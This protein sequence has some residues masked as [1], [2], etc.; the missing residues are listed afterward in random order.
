MANADVLWAFMLEYSKDWGIRAHTH[1][2][3]Q[4]YYITSGEGWMSIE[5]TH[6]H[7][8]PKLCVLI[9]PD[10]EHELFKMQNG[11][12]RMIDIKFYVHDAGLSEELE[13]LPQTQEMNQNFQELLSDIRSEWKL[14]LPFRKN[15]VD[16][17][18]EQALYLLVRAH[19]KTERSNVI[20]SHIL[21]HT[22]NLTGLPQTMAQYIRSRCFDHL[23]LDAMAK[24]LTY[25]RNYLCKVF[26]QA[27]GMTII[28]YA[29]YVRVERALELIC[30]SDEKISTISEMSGFHD[31]H[32]FAKVFKEITKHTPGELR[33]RQEYDMYTDV[34]E[35]GKFIYRYYEP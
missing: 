18:M 14:M 7:L 33:N 24:E 16:I 23:S 28:Q 1:D 12:L 25:N 6:I 30:Y 27:T 22:K 15:M 19:A 26:K 17:L 29:N 13:K 5:N 20:F 21:D 4:L 11:P 32:Y 2:F 35:H 8:L 31:V 9:R 34:L 3:Y 10:Q